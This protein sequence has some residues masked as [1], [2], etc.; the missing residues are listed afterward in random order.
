MT[1]M[2][3]LCAFNAFNIHISFYIYRQASVATFDTQCPI[4]SIKENNLKCTN[5]DSF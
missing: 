3:D 1:I 5:L 2:Q 4:W